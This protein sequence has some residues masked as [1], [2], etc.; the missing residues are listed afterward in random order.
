MCVIEPTIGLG[1]GGMRRQGK[2][3]IDEGHGQEPGCP[4][5]DGVQ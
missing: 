5:G 4:D 2:Y 1:G 3:N